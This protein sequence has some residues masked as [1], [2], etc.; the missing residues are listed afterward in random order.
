[1]FSERPFAQKFLLLLLYQRKGLVFHLVRSSRT[2]NVSNVS[3]LYW[4][5][6][7][8][9]LYYGKAGTQEFSAPS[10]SFHFSSKV[11][12]MMVQKF[13]IILTRRSSLLDVNNSSVLIFRL[14][15]LLKITEDSWV[16]VTIMSLIF[17]YVKNLHIMEEERNQFLFQHSSSRSI[18]V[19]VSQSGFYCPNIQQ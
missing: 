13:K 15:V 11:I 7:S 12:C 4:P 10:E 19:K 6:S 3:L 2:D 1:M 18:I 16:K 5:P 17:H 8:I 14:S 9:L